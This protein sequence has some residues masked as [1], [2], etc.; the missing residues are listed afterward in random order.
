M[1]YK[2]STWEKRYDEINR[3]SFLRSTGVAAGAGVLSAVGSG[4]VAASDLDTQD[5]S[6]YVGARVVTTASSLNGRDAPT[7]DSNVVETLPEGTIGDV[8]SGPE[9]ADGI[10]WWQMW[11]PAYEVTVW[12]AGS[13]LDESDDPESSDPLEFTIQ[14]N[15]NRRLNATGAEIDAAIEALSPDSPLIG[16]GDTIVDVQDTFTVDSLYILAHAVHESAWGTS[17]IAQDHNNLFGY[18]ASDDDPYG[19]A[20]QYDSFE[21]CVWEVIEEVKEL[22]LTPGNWRYNGPNL[23]GVNVYYATDDE[24]DVKIADHYRDLAAQIHDLQV[25]DGDGTTEPGVA[26]FEEGDRV[27]THTSTTAWTGDDELWLGA[28]EAGEIS[29]NEYRIEDDDT[30]YWSVILDDHGWW[31]VDQNALQLE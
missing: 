14:T 17:D 12:C 28:G 11:V 18:G 4:S 9:D 15:L 19:N 21:Q 22:Y 16:L 1:G 23:A 5:T 8:I 26:D 31:W 25:I 24:W 6:L 10:T 2:K 27:E 29:P 3:R 30:V 13:Y 20:E 7:L